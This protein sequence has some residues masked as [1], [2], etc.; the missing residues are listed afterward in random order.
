MTDS[1]Q[2]TRI[3]RIERYFQEFAEGMLELKE[4]QLRTDGQIQELKA[5]QIKTDGQILG[6]KDSHSQLE[7]LL[8]KTIRE[9]RVTQKS[10]GDLGLVQGEVAEDLFYRNVKGL[11]SPLDLRFERIRRNVKVKGLGEY[12]IVANDKGRVLVS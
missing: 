9:F 2:E 3:D 8:D 11:F 6:L 5:T 4:A 7:K 12:D 10:L 1:I